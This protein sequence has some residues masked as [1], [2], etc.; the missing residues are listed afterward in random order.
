LRTTS[1]PIGRSH[2]TE[3]ATAAQSNQSPRLRLAVENASCRTRTPP[4]GRE[5]LLQEKYVNNGHVQHE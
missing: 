5:R 4:A 3:L 1:L 2:S